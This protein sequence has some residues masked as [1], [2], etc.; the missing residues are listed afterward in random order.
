MLIIQLVNLAFS[1][2]FRELIYIQNKTV[3]GNEER[4]GRVLLIPLSG[5]LDGELVYVH[6]VG[7]FHSFAEFP[8]MPAF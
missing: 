4:L 2:G 1:W 7:A 5:I 3:L 6:P 8:E